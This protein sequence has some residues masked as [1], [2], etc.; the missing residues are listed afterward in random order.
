MALDLN[1]FYSSTLDERIEIVN[2]SGE[3]IT[4]IKYFGYFINLYIVDG[5]FVE[6]YYN[7]HSNDIEDVEFLDPS[8]ERLH[9]F[10]AFV[11]LSDLYRNI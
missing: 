3:Y 11:D 7:C 1:M 4:R 6:V 2:N 8:E 5:D 10:T 9:L